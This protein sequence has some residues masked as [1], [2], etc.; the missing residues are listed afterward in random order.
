MLDPFVGTGSLLIPPS[1]FKAIATGCDIDVRVIKGYGV[2]YSK[3]IEKN[4]KVVQ[5]GMDIF[6]NFNEYK[7]ALPQIIRADINLPCFRI[8]QAFDAIICD[9]PYGFRAFSRTVGM[10][11]EKKVKRENRLT[12]KYGNYV[13]GK[14]GPMKKIN[15]ESDSMVIENDKDVSLT[16]NKMIV[17]LDENNKI[18]IEED[19]KTCDPLKQCSVEQI[20][21]NLLKIAA[22]CL[23]SGS[24]LVCLFPTKIQKGDEEYILI[25]YIF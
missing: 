6:T 14:K 5:G 25:K 8:S 15:D 9:P 20:F 24:K 12:E 10:E 13:K 22:I 4:G 7:L 18:N 1:H 2:G 16:D 3:A 23:K 17:E 19:N 21:E 11:D